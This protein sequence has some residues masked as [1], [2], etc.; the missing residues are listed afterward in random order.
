VSAANEPACDDNV[1][2]PR[3]K[4][5][6]LLALA[7]SAAE[8]AARQFITLGF[9]FGVLA[10]ITPHDLGIFTLAYAVNQ[11][12][13]VL[14]DDPIIEALIQ[15][16]DVSIQDWDAGFTGNLLMTL[17]SLVLSI[18]CSGWVANLLHEPE[19]RLAVPAIAACSLLGSFGYVQKGFL[20]RELQFATMARTMLMSQITAGVFGVVLAV[21]GYGYWSLVGNLVVFTLSNGLWF[22]IKCSWKPKLVLDLPRLRALSHYA[23]HSMSVRC[24]ILVR[25]NG[26]PI[27]VGAFFDAAAIG[28]FAL[29]FRIA[30]TLGLFFE[31]MSRQP[32][33]AL[34]SRE[35]TSPSDFS[36]LLLNI[37]TVLG[38]AG[39][40]AFVGL[41]LIG[42]YMPGLV[43]GPSWAPSGQLLPWLCI[44]IA[45][46][47]VLHVISVSLRAQ[48]RVQRA[49]LLL[50]PLVGL[51]LIC[52]VTLSPFGI[53]WALVGMSIRMVLSLPLLAFAAQRWLG[54]P[55]ADLLGRWT[56]PFIGVFAM[57]ATVL[58]V[59]HVSGLGL[60][61]LI[62]ACACGAVTY[63]TIVALGALTVDRRITLAFKAIG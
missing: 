11:I 51:D 20:A 9:S 63:S 39:L 18:A 27:V 1:A 58:L 56:L 36:R 47:V 55:I 22:W 28:Y 3:K 24:V 43:F 31:D 13:S 41:G 46:W 4:A 10:F 30:R 45:G 5:H 12:P 34:M 42:S 52:L 14:L 21:E 61:S 6:R 38:V 19:L 37:V 25:D 29:A 16:H 33:M 23:L 60:P 26:P 48:G 54:M 32:L 59:L 44:I 15:R 49:F 2:L 35:Q 40:P 53:V 57:A 17:G 50:A 62:A 7:W 8:V